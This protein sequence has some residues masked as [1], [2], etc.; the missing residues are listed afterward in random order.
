MKD[1]F[2]FTK[3]VK[4]KMDISA[5]DLPL[6]KIFN[7]YNTTWYFRLKV[8]QGYLVAHKLEINA[9]GGHQYLTTIPEIIIDGEYDVCTEQE[10][11]QA[12]A[13]LLKELDNQC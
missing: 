4:Q 1:N 5:K 12:V 13:L 2:T 11:Y 8:I 9:N 7:G 10:W 3:T 6:Y